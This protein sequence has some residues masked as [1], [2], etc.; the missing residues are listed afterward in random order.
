MELVLENVNYRCNGKTIFRN[1][2]MRISSGKISG[3]IGD[4][5]SGKTTL[6]ELILGLKP[7]DGVILLDDKKI[8]QNNIFKIGVVFD[9]E[10]YFIGKTVYDQLKHSLGTVKYDKEKVE[11]RIKE[12]CDLCETSIEFL[13]KE[14]ETLSTCEKVWSEFLVA[15]VVDPDV[16]ILDDITSRLDY[17][18]KQILNR[19]LKYMKHRLNKTI[20][21]T[22]HDIDFMHK[23]VDYFYVLAEFRVA[24]SGR[25]YDVFKDREFLRLYGIN[26]PKIVDFSD[27]VMKQKQIKIG[28]RD[29][30]ND[31]IKDIYRYVK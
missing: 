6:I 5:G 7:Y 16:L 3:I 23:L 28:Y 4:H 19:V 2:S 14:V 17:N 25:K 27:K 31:L 26:V 8:N 9:R 18:R 29:E 24:L 20:I 11:E 21:I 30:I 10:N 12:I 1:L 22:G 15:T 13:E